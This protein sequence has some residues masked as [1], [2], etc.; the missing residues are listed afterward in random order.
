MQLELGVANKGSIKK[1]TAYNLKYVILPVTTGYNITN[2]ISISGGLELSRLVSVR[3]GKAY[4]KGLPY[5][6]HDISYVFNVSYSISKR[7]GI[8][9]RMV[10]GLLPVF[11][12]YY[13]DDNGDILGIST[14]YN[15]SPIQIILKVR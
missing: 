1:G 11:E 5:L 15:R 13:T 3:I 9:I 7:I 4:V 6:N 2:N 8:D 10:N 12:G 14:E